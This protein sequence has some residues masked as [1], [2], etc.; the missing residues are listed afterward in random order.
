M[1]IER[2]K[3][4]PN[5]KKKR[6]FISNCDG[7]GK[8]TEIEIDIVHKWCFG[9]F[10]AVWRYFGFLI[11]W[12]KKHFRLSLKLKIRFFYTSFDKSF[13]HLSVK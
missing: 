8:K 2:W 13:L 6:F 10:D 11:K 7:Y 12:N 9:K 5:E 1:Q 4:K 3:L